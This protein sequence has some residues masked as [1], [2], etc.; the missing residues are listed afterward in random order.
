MGCHGSHVIID[1][2][3]LII[4]FPNQLQFYFTFNWCFWF[5]AGCLILTFGWYHMTVLLWKN[6]LMRIMLICRERPLA[7]MIKSCIQRNFM[8]NYP[9]VSLWTYRK[10][11][12]V[13]QFLCTFSCNSAWNLDERLRMLFGYA[14]KM[15]WEKFTMFWSI[16]CFWRML[17]SLGCPLIFSHL[18][19]GDVSDSNSVLLPCP[20]SPPN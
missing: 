14:R 16:V 15:L 1:I 18:W 10:I 19:I 17:W 11:F 13:L 9:C 5:E 12:S 8:T 3:L 6:L 20:T 4:C 2:A 7:L